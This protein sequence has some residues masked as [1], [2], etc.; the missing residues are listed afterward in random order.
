MDKQSLVSAPDAAETRDTDAMPQA[1]ERSIAT[2]LKSYL[3]DLLDL[4]LDK[5]DEET[6]F[7]RYGLDSLASVGMIADLG[8]WLGYELDAAAPNDSPSIL[9]LARELAADDKVRAAYV[10]RF[11]CEA[12]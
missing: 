7:D 6:T 8:D 3:A 12:A 10:R 9:L 1:I 2:W 11:G 4:S 5:I